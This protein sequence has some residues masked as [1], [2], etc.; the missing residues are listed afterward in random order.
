MVYVGRLRHMA[1]GAA[2]RY[3]LSDLCELKSNIG[4]TAALAKPRSKQQQ[5]ITIRASMERKGTLKQLNISTTVFIKGQ[6]TKEYIDSGNSVLVLFI[7]FKNCSDLFIHS[8]SLRS[9]PINVAGHGS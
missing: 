2:G 8:S 1:V 3:I 5:N 6:K 7:I 9:V 4:G